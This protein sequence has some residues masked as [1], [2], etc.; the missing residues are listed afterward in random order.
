MKYLTKK[1]LTNKPS[2]NVE[3]LPKEYILVGF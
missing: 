3:E 1:H 2:I